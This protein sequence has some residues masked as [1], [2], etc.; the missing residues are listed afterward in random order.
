MVNKVTLIGNLGADPEVRRL[1]TGAVVASF[2]LAT[3][4]SYK[5]KS[6]EWQQMTEWHDIVLWNKFAESAEAK[7]KKGNKI[8]I[9]G[10]LKAQMW[11]DQIGTKRKSVKI[12]GNFVRLLDKIEVNSNHA[13]TPMPAADD[14]PPIPD[15]D[16][17]F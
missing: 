6:G 1:D 5:D 15:D 2:P 13:P 12:V 17:P 9:E 10:K 11:E 7:L 16:L 14:E 3:N 4:E 8:Y